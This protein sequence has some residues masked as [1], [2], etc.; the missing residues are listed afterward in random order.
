MG[1]EICLACA[2]AL[3]RWRRCCAEACEKNLS[4]DCPL[5]HKVCE[6]CG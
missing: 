2:I 3:R 5:H 1:Q 4:C 6:F